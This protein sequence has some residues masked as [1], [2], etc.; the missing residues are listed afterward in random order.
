MCR[1]AGRV[2]SESRVLSLAANRFFALTV[3]HMKESKYRVGE[4]H[5]RAYFLHDCSD[6]I[7]HGRPV[8]VDRAVAA[9]GFS[10]L[11]RAAGKTP[12]GIGK[13]LLAIRTK[14]IAATVGPV[15]AVVFPAILV[16]HDGHGLCFPLHARVGFF[17][18]FFSMLAN[19]IQET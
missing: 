4:D 10:L 7:T 15:T 5:A 1:V 9:G 19:R 17:H 3:K 12:A 18:C 11:K 14:A 8:A 13:Q 2:S 6:F 16:N